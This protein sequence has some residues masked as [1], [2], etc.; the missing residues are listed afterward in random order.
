LEV[1]EGTGTNA[2]TYPSKM[3]TLILPTAKFAVEVNE[4]GSA[5]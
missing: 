2:T 3:L 1:Q 5:A 4:A